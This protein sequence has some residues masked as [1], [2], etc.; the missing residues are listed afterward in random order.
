M[1]AKSL[2]IPPLIYKK[3]RL[4]LWKTGTCFLIYV[5]KETD[6][7]TWN[8]LPWT[9]FTKLYNRLAKP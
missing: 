9:E 7:I 3:S 4:D 5:V 2:A 8:Q 6:Q 1:Y